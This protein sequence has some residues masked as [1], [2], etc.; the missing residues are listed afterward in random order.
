MAQL[1][2]WAPSSSPLELTSSPTSSQTSQAASSTSWPSSAGG[3]CNPP[4]LP[5]QNSS[6][7][8][9]RKTASVTSSYACYAMGGPQCGSKRLKRNGSRATRTRE[10][11]MSE[12][13]CS[14]WPEM[15]RQTCS[16]P[17]LSLS[18]ETAT[19]PAF[20]SPAGKCC[21]QD[22]KEQNWMSWMTTDDRPGDPSPSCHTC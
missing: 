14:P 16:L 21:P 6:Q 12:T 1:Q 9:R 8:L 17:A 18:E 2:L 3:M 10:C 11:A 5:A 20:V 19:A 4:D 15:H 22:R 13:P 7:S